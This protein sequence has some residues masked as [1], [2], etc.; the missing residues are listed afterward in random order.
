MKCTEWNQE[1][2][3]QTNQQIV[4]LKKRRQKARKAV[5]HPLDV[6]IDGINSNPHFKFYWEWPMSA[7]ADFAT[8]AIV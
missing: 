7:M 3:A 4:M 5:K 6:I 2:H 1:V 8:D